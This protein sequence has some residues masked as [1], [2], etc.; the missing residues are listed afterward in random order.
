MFILERPEGRQIAIH[1][2]MGHEQEAESRTGSRDNSR[3]CQP[4]EGLPSGVPALAPVT[5][6]T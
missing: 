5:P 2:A 3:C 6:V 4:R 1:K